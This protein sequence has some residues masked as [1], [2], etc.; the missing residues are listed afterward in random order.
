MKR[1]SK[2]TYKRTHSPRRPLDDTA[3]LRRLQEGGALAFPTAPTPEELRK[4]EKI[5]FATR[6]SRADLDRL[7]ACRAAAGLTKADM[8]RWMIR[9]A[10]KHFVEKVAVVGSVVSSPA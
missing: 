9:Y 1:T 5:M 8:L 6:L 3:A 4:D 2:T 7:S 10:H